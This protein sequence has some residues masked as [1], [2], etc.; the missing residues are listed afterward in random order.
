MATV[1][2]GATRQRQPARAVRAG[3]GACPSTPERKSRRRFVP[4]SVISSASCPLGKLSKITRR[5]RPDPTALEI[6]YAKQRPDKNTS[7]D[8]AGRMAA[9]TARGAANAVAGQARSARYEREVGRSAHDV[10]SQRACAELRHKSVT[11]DGSI[12]P[13]RPRKKDLARAK[14]LFSNQEFWWA[15]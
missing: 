4:T 12:R 9:R 2:T 8:I 3:V 15:L 14:S 6:P 10:C 13:M 11:T 5:D 1:R 7:R